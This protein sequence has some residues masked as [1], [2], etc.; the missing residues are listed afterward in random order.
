MVEQ[1]DLRFST[2][3][4]SFLASCENAP[5]AC[6]VS[7]NS[8]EVLSVKFSKRVLDFIVYQCVDLSLV[9]ILARP[10]FSRSIWH[11]FGTV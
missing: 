6:T 9:E 8:L 1:L 2:L 10:R 11:S 5:A 4:S 3:V 7:P